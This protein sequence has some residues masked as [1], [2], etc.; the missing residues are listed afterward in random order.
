MT[1]AEIQTEIDSI[2]NELKGIELQKY[3]RGIGAKALERAKILVEDDS[4]LVQVFDYWER[5]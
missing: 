2:P 3:I 4:V 1:I 5:I